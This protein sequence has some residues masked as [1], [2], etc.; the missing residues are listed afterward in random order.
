MGLLL[1][2]GAAVGRSQASGDGGHGVWRGKVVERLHRRQEPVI[3]RQLIVAERL[4]GSRIAARQRP[5]QVAAG[6]EGAED[7]DDSGPR[8]PAGQDVR[9]ARGLAIVA[10]QDQWQAGIKRH[11]C[12]ARGS[13]DL[14]S[15]ARVKA[16]GSQ[17]PVDSRGRPHARP[18][19]PPG[20]V[21]DAGVV[22]WESTQT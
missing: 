4:D 17:Q 8:V 1:I 11:R 10:E 16:R 12:N 7:L 2:P 20:V 21:P 6:I 9:L 13:H 15:L 3:G 14:D 22:N 5:G 18:P 19:H